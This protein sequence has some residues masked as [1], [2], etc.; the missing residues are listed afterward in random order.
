MGR[1][2]QPE[3]HVERAGAAV[4]SRDRWGK[5]GLQ[6]NHRFTSLH[7]CSHYVSFNIHSTSSREHLLG[8]YS[9][10]GRQEWVSHVT[11]MSSWSHILV[12]EPNFWRSL[13]SN[14]GSPSLAA[15]D[16][17]SL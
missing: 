11:F 8:M 9:S 10:T 16:A 3:A 6:N 7:S 4:G 1:D 15:F 14:P 5:Q 12:R 2:V 17:S 13:H